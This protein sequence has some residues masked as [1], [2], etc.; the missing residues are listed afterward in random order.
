[1]DHIALNFFKL[2]GK[3]LLNMHYSELKALNGFPIIV[4]FLKLYKNLI[5]Y[6]HVFIVFGHCQN[7]CKIIFEL[8][9]H[10]KNTLA[11]CFNSPSIDY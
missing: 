4:S 2:L 10:M 6:L 3:F 9:V 11:K 7:L 5:A 1:M 8:Q